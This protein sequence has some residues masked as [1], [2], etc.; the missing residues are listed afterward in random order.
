[1]EVANNHFNPITLLKNYFSSSSTVEDTSILRFLSKPSEIEAGVFSLTD[2]VTTFS[3][4]PFPFTLLQKDLYARKLQGYYGFRGTLVLTLQV[5]AERFQQGRYMLVAVPTGGVGQGLVTNEWANRHAYS[6]VQRTQLPRVEI[7][8]GTQTSVELRLPHSM[9]QDMVSIQSINS[10]KESEYYVRIFPY[11]PL[12]TPSG[13]TTAKYTL[14]AHYEDVEL[15]GQALPVELQSG[16]VKKKNPAS[17]EAR[18]AGVG[19]VE[20]TALKISK[21]S[22]YLQPVPVIGAFAGQLTWVSNIVANVASVFGWSAPANLDKGYRVKYMSAMYATNVDKVDHS[23]PMA[24]SSD[25]SVAC[26]PL[27]NTELDELDIPHFAGR[28]SWQDSFQFSNTG[29]PENYLLAT[30]NASIY[31]TGSINSSTIFGGTF[32]NVTPAQYLASLFAFWRGSIIFRL[33]IVKTEFHSGRISIEFNPTSYGQTS[34]VI[35][36]DVAPFV[37]R[38]IVDIRYVNEY[39]F[40]VPYI[41]NIPYRNCDAGSDGFSFGRID[42]RVIDPLVAPDSVSPDITFHVE[43][44]MGQ[45]AEFAVLN[46]KT[47][48]YAPGVVELQSGEIT[49]I[50]GAPRSMFQNETAAI[51]VGEKVTSLRLLLKRF[52][53]VPYFQA[54]NSGQVMTIA[55]FGCTNADVIPSLYFPSYN[56]LYSDLSQMFMYSRGGVRYKISCGTTS[57]SRLMAKLYYCG[58]SWSMVNHITNS[59]PANP[60]VYATDQIF[61]NNAS[62]VIEN[63]NPGTF[64]ELGIPQYSRT[65]SRNNIEYTH[66]DAYP[67][68]D[69]PYGL[70]NNVFLQID[71]YDPDA[72]SYKDGAR[73]YYILRSCAEDG[74][75][76]YFISIPPI[77]LGGL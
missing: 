49:P 15:I 42:I 62:Y 34:A 27:G 19:P 68:A 24:L 10:P 23:L 66:S 8:L 67:A 35:T 13:S 55:P 53:S 72:S 3:W 18:K 6:L 54:A 41:S 11:S 39:C 17:E 21:A 1:M 45:D 48:I 36:D 7:D 30:Y 57:A 33:K 20:S 16:N 59:N 51:A 4:K 50:G 77:S 31:P 2:T 32:Y 29:M 9:V 26:I 14:W 69:S 28:F 44:A 47:S 75:F 37:Y 43:V 56:D 70:T 52:F 12:S 71:T 73:K 76:S 74:N 64:M 25:N 58:T 5:N 65:H 40:E 63:V 61:M 38:D 60:N 22:S 46:K